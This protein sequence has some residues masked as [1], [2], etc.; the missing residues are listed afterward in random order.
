MK[1]INQLDD[2]CSTLLKANSIIRCYTTFKGNSKGSVQ[3]PSY[4]IEFHIPRS[5]QVK[6][7]LLALILEDPDQHLVSGPHII[8]IQAVCV[9]GGILQHSH[10]PY[11]FISI[12]LG[13][14]VV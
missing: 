3:Y 12:Q 10:D 7:L 8:A 11:G 5:C 6:P 1:Q 14:V 13:L 4:L 9:F 2:I